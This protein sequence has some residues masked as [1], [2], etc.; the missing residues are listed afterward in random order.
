MFENC[1]NKPK[2]EDEKPVVE[3]FQVKSIKCSDKFHVDNIY[4]HVLNI[5]I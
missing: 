3:A 2:L 4:A 5:L 1:K